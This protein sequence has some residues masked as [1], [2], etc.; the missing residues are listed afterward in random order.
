MDADDIDE[1]G[2]HVERRELGVGGPEVS[3]VGL[4]CMN[5]SGGYGYADPGESLRVIGRALDRGVTLFDTAD[6]YADGENERLLGRGIAGRRAEAVLVTRGGVRARTPGGPPTVLDGTPAYLRS[7]C[8]AS[9][10]RLGVDSIDVYLL[11]RV[12]PEVP[13]EESVGALAE[14]RQEGKIKHIGLSEASAATLRRAH[15]VHPIIALESEYSLWERHVEAEI[16]PAA[17]ESGTTLIAHS[18]LGKGFLTGLLENPDDLGEGDHRRNHPRLQSGNFQHNRRMVDEAQEVATELG[19]SPARLALAWLL[20]RGKDIVPIPG[21]RR[22]SHMEDNI[23]AVRLALSEEHTA[24]LDRIFRP[25][26]VA[27]SRHPG[28]RRT[29]GADRDG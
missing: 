2:W 23:A 3:A 6:F 10:R 27:G 15:A 16:L 9:L 8:E 12:D 4:G 28:H 25:G 26:R 7:A 13:V 14:L 5:L 11:G 29:A 17:R 1:L 19:V 24:R 21:S 18:P 20:A 22:G